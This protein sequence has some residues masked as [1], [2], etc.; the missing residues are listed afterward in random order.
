VRA[1]KPR[2]EN[3]RTLVVIFNINLL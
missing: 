3:K 2:D 1:E